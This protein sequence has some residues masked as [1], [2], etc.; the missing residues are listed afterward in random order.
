MLLSQQ[1]V[2]LDE[3][4]GKF[5]T[6]ALTTMAALA[7][8]VLA[9]QTESLKIGLSDIINSISRLSS[10]LMLRQALGKK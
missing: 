2:Y 5:A 4:I 1:F 3:Y 6:L 10:R 9:T 7:V 8:S